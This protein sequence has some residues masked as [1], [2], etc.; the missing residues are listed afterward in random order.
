MANNSE[1]TLKNIQ[2]QLDTRLNDVQTDAVVAMIRSF[3]KDL[4][5]MNVQDL[6]SLKSAISSFRASTLSPEVA[7]ELELLLTSITEFSAKLE[8]EKM[9]EERIIQEELKHAR[10]SG[11]SAEEV[12]E[13]ERNEKLAGV[14]AVRVDDY[15]K[16]KEELF[17]EQRRE[18][19]FLNALSSGT[20]TSA[21]DKCLYLGDC[22]SAGLRT[23]MGLAERRQIDRQDQAME[24]WRHLPSVNEHNQRKID[25]VDASLQANISQ[26]VREHLEQERKQLQTTLERGQQA[27]EGIDKLLAGESKIL[28]KRLKMMK[29]GILPKKGGEQFLKNHYLVFEEESR[30]NP[31]ATGVE[32]CKQLA[33]AA[34]IDLD[35]L[36]SEAELL[37]SARRTGR[38][39]RGSSENSKTANQSASVVSGLS[40]KKVKPKSR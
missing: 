33:K 2:H 22:N 38:Q 10:N 19:D 12:R 18:L 27:L 21:E 4:A 17:S 36:K 37:R 15:F 28:D 40:I 31:N 34:D 1:K 26:P 3:Q 11:V 16:Y 35:A 39:V 30:V 20:E 29:L 5:N 6:A 14:I 32:R 25:A 9:I 8:A 23:K 7:G 13:Y 24:M